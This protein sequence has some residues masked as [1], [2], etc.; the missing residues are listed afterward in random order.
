MLLKHRIMMVNRNIRVKIIKQRTQ[1]LPV[2]VI[3]VIIQIERSIKRK[4]LKRIQKKR[5][6]QRK[7]KK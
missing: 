5:K 2:I 1:I 6:N 4:S 3:I 7:I